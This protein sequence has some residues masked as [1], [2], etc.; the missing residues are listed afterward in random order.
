MREC[1]VRHSPLEK[2][3]RARRR[4]HREAMNA[5]SQLPPV[6][7]L[8][9]QGMTE[10]V[11]LVETPD[12]E[13]SDEAVELKIEPSVQ[14]GKVKIADAPMVDNSDAPTKIRARKRVPLPAATKH[15]V[16][17]RD[18]GRCTL[19]DVSGARYSQTRWLD[20]HHVVEVSNGGDDSP[21]NL[22]TVCRRHHRQIHMSYDIRHS[23]A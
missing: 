18:G 5:H 6:S 3:K 12:V 7:R 10:S 23:F 13:I 15:F 19:N 21:E 22:R 17:L 20:I 16:S 9:S 8:S 1:L 11:Q 14:T 4:T 2:A